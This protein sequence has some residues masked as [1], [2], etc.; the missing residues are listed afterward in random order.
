MSPDIMVDVSNLDHIILEEDKVHGNEEVFA[1]D[2]DTEPYLTKEVLA[3]E[4][5][6]KKL[7]PS[8]SLKNL[9]RK[10]QRF[11]KQNISV[12]IDLRGKNQ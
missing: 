7:C 8:L 2:P 5:A 6:E 10:K 9:K 1:P 12:S 11:W 4:K 3:K